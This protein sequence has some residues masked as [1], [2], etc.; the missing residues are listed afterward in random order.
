EGLRRNAVAVRL[1]E[2]TLIVSVADVLWQRQLES[3]AGE[4]LFRVNHLL[5]G[6]G[7]DQIVFQISPRDIPPANMDKPDRTEASH[8]N[9]LPTELLFAAGTIADE[10]LRTRFLHA[11]DNLIARRDSHLDD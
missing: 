6:A 11:A 2:R 3:M 5:G 10:E 9:A 7:V 1:R 4:L 8:A